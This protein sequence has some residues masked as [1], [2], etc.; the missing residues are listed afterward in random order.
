MRWLDILR[1]RFRSLFNSR[2]AEDA[3]NAELRFHFENQVEENIARG[4]RPDEAKYAALRAI[5]GMTQIEEQCRDM[6]RTAWIDNITQDV[7][8]GVRMLAKSWGLT[9]IITLTLGLGVGVNT[10]MFSVL[11]GWLLRPLPVR[12]PTQITVLA[13]QNQE[14]HGSQ[15]S[16]PDFLDFQKQ[17]DR[18]SDLFAY[19]LP[20]FGGL[21]ADGQATQF[22]FSVV[23]G[24]YFTALGVSPSIGRLLLPG[25]NEKPGEPISIVLGYSFWQRRFGGDRAIAGRQVVFNGRPATILGVASP[26]F[27]GTFFSA[28]MDG[29]VS[30]SATS[31]Q[32]DRGHRSLVVLGRLKD[33]LR[34]AQT[35]ANV[36]AERLAR[37]YPATDKGLTVRVIPEKLARPAPLVT[38]FVP[39]IAMLFLFLA[40]LVLAVAGMSV[41]NLLAAQA[42]ARQHEMAI[43]A[44]LGASR[45]RLIRQTLVESLL[46]ALLGG[47]AGVVLGKWTLAAAGALLHSVATSSSNISLSLDTSLD[48]RVFCYAL[49]AA[50]LTGI[51]FAAWP[52]IRAGRQDVNAALHAGARAD[53]TTRS[54]G[55]RGW[56]VVAQVAGSLML[57]IAAGLF[58]RSFQRA[59]HMDL[60]FDPDH[61]LAVLVDPHE[62][63]YSETRARTFYRD[64]EDRLRAMPGVQSASVSF[65]VPMGS[66][67][68]GSP[69]YA[70]GRPP[71]P[72]ISFNGPAP[73]ISFN[74]VVPAYFETMRV[75]LVA[76]REFRESDNESA[77]LV[78]I[79]NQAMARRLWADE[80]PIGKRFSLKSANGPWVEVVGVARNGQYWFVSPDPQ[81]YFF[82]PVAQHFT[83][84]R[85]IELRSSVPPESLIPAVE[86]QIR[87]LAP[88]LPV[89]DVRTMRETVNGLAGL[90]VFRLAATLAAAMGILGLTLAVVG[91]YGVVS[92][93]VNRRTHEIGVRVALG[94][95]PRDILILVSSAAAKLVAIGIIA[96]LLAAVALSRAMA[97]L[98]IGISATDPATYAMVAILLA[99]VAAVACGIPGRRAIRVQ[100][101][102]ALRNE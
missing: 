33:S 46:L 50:I 13:A 8:Y 21:S 82:V 86:E 38:S 53:S 35:E 27:H 43:R 84:A 48:W 26:E 4:M 60:G 42:M 23:T 52:A 7:R 9:A 70:E 32:T 63:G 68:E 2:S 47:I 44:S 39:I 83:S 93:S 96:G 28:D 56:L 66:P 29:Y 64:L 40:A 69:V 79:V 45:G 62:I 54:I 20:A 80:D 72:A 22:G 3:L 57:L 49:A 71:A 65:T 5:G 87:R 97:K 12:A 78:A 36:I 11:N 94:A 16:Y 15:F 100:P 34:A 19:G 98:L 73:A 85:T 75:P 95:E 77:P 37:D 58:V 25:E 10:A 76:G 74:S 55:I 90:F 81:P 17:A 89:M 59:E 31:N 99:A 91:V 88:D 61:V 41:A 6:R 14:R 1:I 101:V 30:L 18:F 92:F 51:L 67:S 102:I 24:N